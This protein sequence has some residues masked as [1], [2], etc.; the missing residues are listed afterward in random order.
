M[1]RKDWTLL[2]I[3]FNDGEPMQPVQ[4][5]KTL[6]LLGK[7]CR[8]DVGPKFYKFRP[9]NYG[10]FSSEVYQDAE[11]LAAEG[12]V[13]IERGQWSEYSATEAGLRRARQIRKKAPKTAVSFLE[14]AVDWARQLSFQELV[15]A[16]YEEFP[17]QRKHSVFQE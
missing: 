8:A 16:I 6:F 7:R 5:Q 2:A 4:L 3:S 13:R 15:S 12:F 14:Q 17:E 9:Y 10:P 11:E 1:D